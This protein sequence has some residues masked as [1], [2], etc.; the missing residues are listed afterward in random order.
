MANAHGMVGNTGMHCTQSGW[1]LPPLV[2]FVGILQL[3]DPDHEYI[4][5]GFVPVTQCIWEVIHDLADMY[6][7]DTPFRLL[8]LVHYMLHLNV[9][10][11][12]CVPVDIT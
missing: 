11:C 3:F 8:V 4:R 12:M 9:Y 6:P 10:I 5:L 2:V 1:C 7:G